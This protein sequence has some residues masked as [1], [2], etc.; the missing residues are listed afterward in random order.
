[1]TTSFDT[2]RSLLERNKRKGGIRIT[3]CAPVLTLDGKKYP[4][5]DFSKTGFEAQLP[6][7]Y[8]KQ[9]LPQRGTLEF[10]AAG[11]HCVQEIDFKVVRITPR[12]NVGATYTVSSSNHY[13]QQ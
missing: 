12:G 11:F 1:M 4:V 13:K 5:N 6:L 2:V 3:E 10:D 7:E 8:R 9:G